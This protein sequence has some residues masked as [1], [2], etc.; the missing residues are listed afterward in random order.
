[1]QF[2]QTN[3]ILTVGIEV[4]AFPIAKAMEYL[5]TKSWT[6]FGK[7]WSLNPGKFNAKEHMLIVS[8]TNESIP[9]KSYFRSILTFSDLLSLLASRIFCNPNLLLLSLDYYG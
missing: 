4:V 6:M 9:R 2:K 8:E 7:K 1:M 5:P 3:R